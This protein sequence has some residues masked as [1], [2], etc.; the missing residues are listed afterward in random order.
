ME[1]EVPAPADSGLI[2]SRAAV[3]ERKEL[4]GNQRST[5]SVEAFHFGYLGKRLRLY[6]EGTR[7][8]QQKGSS[9]ETHPVWGLLMRTIFG[10]GG[11]GI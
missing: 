8:V 10:S 5:N 9:E 1:R 7:P 11:G 2:R 4:G 3:P 6:G